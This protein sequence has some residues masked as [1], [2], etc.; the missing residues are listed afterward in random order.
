[1]SSVAGLM[2]VPDLHCLLTHV[3]FPA[4]VTHDVGER[5]AS[6]LQG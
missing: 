6:W 4:D 5:G 3:A 2:H 1:M